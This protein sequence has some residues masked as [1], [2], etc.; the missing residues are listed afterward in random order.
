MGFY[1]HHSKNSHGVYIRRQ[2]RDNENFRFTLTCDLALLRLLLRPTCL[3]RVVK[4]LGYARSSA[5]CL[6]QDYLQKGIIDVVARER[7][8]SGLEK[9]YYRLTDTGLLL[10]EVTER[11]VKSYFRKVV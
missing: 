11:V 8:P 2:L 4:E 9:R 1:L 7:L 3:Y 6:L 5:Y 10:L